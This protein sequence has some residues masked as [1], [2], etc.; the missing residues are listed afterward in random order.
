MEKSVEVKFRINEKIK[1]EIKAFLSRVAVRTIS[2]HQIDTYYVPS[3]RDF[4]VNG[5]TIECIRIREELDK[6]K[7]SYKKIHFDADPIYC[8]EYETEIT[9]KDNMEKI[10]FA[11]NFSTQM[12]IDKFRESYFHTELEFSFDTVKDV[13]EF[14]EVKARG[15]NANLDKI[16]S[17]VETYGLSKAD[18]TYEGL[19]K[20]VKESKNKRV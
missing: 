7:L 16:F 2:T 3:F 6:I 1:Q 19:Q 14:M 13:G 5:E 17:F 4:E 12:V 9:S 20:I 15:E 11:L 10:L 18:V 8:D